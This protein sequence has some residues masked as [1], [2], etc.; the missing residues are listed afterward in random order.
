[1]KEGTFMSINLT[2]GQKIDLTKGNAGLSK[3]KV[4]LG[5]DPVK[6]K[7]GGFLGSLFGGGGETNVDCDSFILLLGDNDKLQKKGIIYFGEK[8]SADGAITHHGDNLTGDGDG[9]DEEI[10][11]ELARIDSSIKKIVICVNIYQAKERNQE[12]SKL[13]NAYV[14]L[15]NS[16]NGQEMMRYT[17]SGSDYQGKTAMIFGEVYRHSGEWKF[18]AI[19]EGTADTAIDGLARR[20]V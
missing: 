4:G 18:N 16:Q 11:V 6:S 19:G 10:S 20:Y 13:Q 12:F 3:I 17:L 15:I 14:R 5:W 7:G 2:K 1:M 9:D 8:K